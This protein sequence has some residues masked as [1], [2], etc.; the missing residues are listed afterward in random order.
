MQTGK[1]AQIILGTEA[2]NIKYSIEQ[3]IKKGMNPKEIIEYERALKLMNPMEGE[4]VAL[5]EVPDEVFQ[6]NY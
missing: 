2:E 6:K 1:V 5:E 4:I 3:I